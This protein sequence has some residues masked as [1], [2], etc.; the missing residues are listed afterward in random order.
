M[1]QPMEQSQLQQML[2]ALHSSSSRGT[3]IGAIIQNLLQLAH[4]D[5][6]LKL[7]SPPTAAPV[8]LQ[9]FSQ[10]LSA[11]AG[12][13]NALH[14]P[15]VLGEF[16]GSR[17]FRRSKYEL[18]ALQHVQLLVWLQRV[19]GA[20]A[21]GLARS[22]VDM[23]HFVGQMGHAARVMLFQPMLI[24]CLQVMRCVGTLGTEEVPDSMASA[25]AYPSD[26]ATDAD[27]VEWLQLN[28]LLQFHSMFREVL[29][30]T[31]MY[32]A[33]YTPGEANLFNCFLRL[34][35]IYNHLIGRFPA[36]C[37]LSEKEQGALNQLCTK[38]N[39][40]FSDGKQYKAL[41]ERNAYGKGLMLQSQ[42]ATSFEAAQY[43]V[44]DWILPFMLTFANLLK[45]LWTLWTQLKRRNHTSDTGRRVV[46][47]LARVAGSCVVKQLEEARAATVG[48]PTLPPPQPPPGTIKPGPEHKIAIGAGGRM[49]AFAGL[50][51]SESEQSMLL[52]LPASLGATSQPPQ[53]PPPPPPS[54]A[55]SLLTSSTNSG[56][57]QPRRHAQQQV[58][59]QFSHL[60]HDR[61]SARVRQQSQGEHGTGHGACHLSA[62]LEGLLADSGEGWASIVRKA[63][64]PAGADPGLP[65]QLSSDRV[66]S[67][68]GAVA[69]G[70]GSASEEQIR[71]LVSRREQARAARDFEN[72][73]RLRDQLS[74]LGVSVDDQSKTWRSC[75]GQRA[76]MI[77]AEGGR[78]ARG[79]GQA[80]SDEEIERLVRER[81]QARF[82]SD[83]KTADRL[84]D[85]LER[86]GVLLD[87][88]ENRW[89]AADGRSGQIGPVNISAAHAHK[90]A[91][92]GAAKLSVEEIERL[93]LQREQARARRDYKSA[94]VL[95][96]QLEKHGVY[97][98][99]KEKK[100][101]SADGRSGAIVVSTLANE[102]IGRVLANRQAARLRHD[103]KTADRLRD[104]LNEQGLSVDDK[105][106]HW[107]SSDGRSGSIDP[108]TCELP[109]PSARESIEGG[110][111]AD[112]PLHK[113]GSAGLLPKGN[114]ESSSFGMPRQITDTSAAE[115]AI[116]AAA[117]SG[118]GAFSL[119]APCE[120]KPE[121][122]SL[123][124]SRVE[125]GEKKKG[126][127]E[128]ERRELAKQ[129][130]SVTGAS[131]RLCEKALHAHADDMERAADWLLS[132]GEHRGG[133][134]DSA[135]TDGKSID[136]AMMMGAAAGEE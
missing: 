3:A 113:P 31:Q 94:D 47:G 58:Q 54:S 112:F 28:L 36:C 21:G 123:S 122:K 7:V 8:D 128:K 117:A 99:P 127:S 42:G 37:P 118:V 115:A 20:L 103:F 89:Q 24:H 52:A 134:E 57:H 124:L 104:Q 39:Q 59:S 72:A 4:M 43:A 10:H 63:G 129:L 80:L 116:A 132:Q 14:E 66:R 130:R 70:V 111:R 49:S 100:W 67:A 109:A 82:T 108:F 131:A 33:T 32:Q 87:P 74:V 27:R 69:N 76:G 44:R 78:G 121:S 73:D 45:V 41:L 135:S 48:S 85:Q 102:E 88:K 107:E 30:N 12:Q 51:E 125:K 136:G 5:G 64:E 55:T 91:R 114:G 119:Q 95:R 79:I 75:D 22:G 13:L 34:E 18:F 93:L 50:H 105:R 96:E 1:V 90:A 133:S 110:G 61:T 68:P 106:N 98:D 86:A 6:P 101:H 25:M 60:P 126:L 2:E 65:S 26:N 46:E 77:A 83:Y 84:R 38:L 15:K 92:A 35:D 120:V 97:L 71:T 9:T 17:V 29:F 40:Y 19:Q 62:E 81:E 16:L 11:L 53:P 23:L 56:L